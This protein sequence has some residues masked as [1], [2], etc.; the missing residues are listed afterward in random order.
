MVFLVKTEAKK[1]LSTSAI[2]IALVTRSPTTFNS[3]PVS[4]PNLSFDV[5]ELVES[6]LV[7]LHIPCQTQLQVS[8]GFSNS[9]SAR[10]P[11][12]MLLLGCL[13]LLP[14][15][16]HLSTTAIYLMKIL[17]QTWR[18]AI[19]FFTLHQPAARQI[20]LSMSPSLYLWI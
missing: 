18:R 13:H 2:S 16:V 3:G 10:S 14:L 20:A 8:V 5:Y 12:S 17:Q 19:R 9:V 4:A 6:F 15:F 1:A 11:D 7:V